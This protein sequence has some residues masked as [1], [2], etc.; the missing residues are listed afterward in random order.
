MTTGGIMVRFD[1]FRR[2]KLYQ[3]Q[4]W[5]EPRPSR[6]N[7]GRRG[8]NWTRG[9]PKGQNFT[10][11][12]YTGL[13]SGALRLNKDGAATRACQIMRDGDILC[14]WCKMRLGNMFLFSVSRPSFWAFLFLRRLLAVRFPG[15]CHICI[16][17]VEHWNLDEAEEKLRWLQW[18]QHSILLACSPAA[19]KARKLCG[20]YSAQEKNKESNPFK[21]R[22]RNLDSESFFKLS[23]IFFATLCTWWT[24]FALEW[25]NK[26]TWAQSGRFADRDPY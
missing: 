9:T 20:F 19:G 2:C 8:I 10:A 16:R 21:Q 18:G 15:C 24:I 25:G 22:Q 5:M 3:R 6:R 1:L 13:A 4:R 7:P 26:I 14:I 23:S 11:K 17:K 12:A